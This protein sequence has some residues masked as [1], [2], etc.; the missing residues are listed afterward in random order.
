M[1]KLRHIDELLKESLGPVVDAGEYSSDWLAIEKRLKRRKNRIYAMWFSLALIAL[2]SISIF[3]FDSINFKTELSK[4]EGKPASPSD[5][6]ATN[7]KDQA[8]QER[9]QANNIE[10]YSEFNNQQTSTVDA[11]SEPAINSEFTATPGQSEAVEIPVA[12]PITVTP[13]LPEVVKLNSISTQLMQWPV[14]PNYSAIEQLSLTKVEVPVKEKSKGF[15]LAMS[16]M[17]YGVSFTPGLSNKTTSTRSSL[18]GL[19]N[20]NYILPQSQELSAFSYSTSFNAEWH[21][22]SNLFVG[23]G[24]G[25]TSKAEQVNYNYE[26]TEDPAVDVPNATITQYY[27]RLPWEVEKVSY[28]GSNSYHFVEIPLTVGYRFNLSKNLELRNQIDVSYLLLYSGLGKKA[29]YTY[30]TLYDVSDL[31]NLRKSNISTTIKSG[32]YYNFKNFVIGAEP[33]AGLNLNSLSNENSAIKIKPYSY[34]FNL[35]TNIKL[36]QR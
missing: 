10:N 34:G 11:D 27:K 25:I 15:M 18:A 31:N 35:T 16:H 2:T 36:N 4:E 20:R 32:V 5:L 8:G 24:F 21:F 28:K 30:L 26:I 22:R 1:D 14:T 9:N 7:Q 17:E 33:L 12:T 23:T 19:I 6:N 29:D 13:N 3:T